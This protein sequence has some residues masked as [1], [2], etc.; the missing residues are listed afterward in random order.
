MTRRLL[1]LAAPEA[2]GVAVLY[3]LLLVL[4][5]VDLALPKILGGIIDVLAT[6]AFPT[7]GVCLFLG[8]SVA[9]NGMRAAEGVLRARVSSGVLARLRERL[10]A[11]VQSLSFRYHDRVRAGEVIARAT[12]DVERVSPFFGEFIFAS[13]EL[14]LLLGGAAVMIFL[15]DRWLGAGAFLASSFYLYLVYRYAVPLRKKWEEIGDTYDGVSALV[16]QSVAG[17]RVVKTFGAAG[18]EV[19]R[20]GDR[21]NVYRDQCI[22]GETLWTVR[23]PF[24]QF[25]FWMA[26]PLTLAWGGLQVVEGRM[27]V[28]ALAA[29]LF[30]LGEMNNRLR[31]VT[32]LVGDLE[33]GLAS[34]GRLFEILDAEEALPEA[35][36]PSIP[37][38]REGRI[39]L[40]GACFE[41]VDDQPALHRV[42]L[43]IEPGE[44]VAIVGP[45]GS[46]KSTLM[47]LLPRFYDVTE[48]EI[49]LDGVDLRSWPLVELRKRIGLVFQET[50]LFSATA[51]EN[52]AFGRPEA[53]R[54]D[55][56]RAARIAQAHDF[57]AALPKGYETMI[58]ERGVNLSGGQRQRIAIARAV[59]SDPEVLLLDD[60]L[61]SV[62]SHTE[63]A[64]QWAIAG[65]AEGRTTVIIAQRLSTVLH[66]DR[67][68]V[69]DEGKVVD[70]GTHAELMSRCELY[71]ALFRGQWV[72]EEKGAGQ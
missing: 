14:V 33:T 15:I 25:C 50:F 67:I 47:A 42:D 4:L 27:P 29:A 48:G 62:D 63:I 6:K 12:R 10:L 1:G 28:G 52:I 5:G 45:T 58:G 3:A 51:A 35:A 69:L 56:E 49:R 19:G 39:D 22:E 65:A 30:Y 26:V 7:L 59:L 71:K 43:A 55:V 11:K 9:R 16:Q 44:T 38:C 36:S 68:V 24:A 41:Y 72:G 64:L 23:S 21:I 2:R 53:S 17:V 20:Y 61:S 8:L 40:S 46:G 18:R 54:E 66:A 37:E 31:T 60:A 70:Q 57:I 32:R 13:V 34:A